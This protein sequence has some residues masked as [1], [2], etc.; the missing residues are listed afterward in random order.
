MSGQDARSRPEE[1]A[2]TAPAAW[3]R[4]WSLRGTCR[5]ADVMMIRRAPAPSRGVISIDTRVEMTAG[6][7]SKFVS[8]RCSDI[9]L[10]FP[11]SFFRQR[12]LFASAYTSFT[13]YTDFVVDGENYAS[14]CVGDNRNVGK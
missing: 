7:L 14:M 13:L 5:V 1:K 11:I 12:I 2:T 10:D 9:D 8:A 3:I 4:H 6:S